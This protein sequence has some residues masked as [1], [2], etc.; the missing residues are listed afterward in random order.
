MAPFR[1]RDRSNRSG[2]GQVEHNVLE[3]L[4]INQYREV[5]ITIGPNSTDNKQSDKDPSILGPEL[6]MPKDSHLLPEHSQ[7]ILR[8]ARRGRVYQAPA[9]LEEDRENMDDE[10]E[11][12]EVQQG[13]TIKKYVKVARHLEGPEPEFLAKRRKGLPSQYA[14]TNGQPTIQA[15]PLRETKVKKLDS[16]GNVNVYKVLVPEGQTVEG[17]VQ[18][19]DPAA[20]E[21]AP[22]TAA[23]GTVVEGV[24]I[25]NAEGVV[26]VNDI[27]QQT[28]P[29]R[30][31]PPP[32]KKRHGPGRGH[33][34]VVA[35][36]ENAAGQGT[37]AAGSELLAVPNLKREGQSVEPSD[38]DGDTPMADA[39]DEEEGE[40]ESDD[41]EA[42][43]SKHSPT[44][45]K[46]ASPARTS[47]NGAS[48]TPLLE[49]EPV[50]DPVESS[51]AEPGIAESAEPAAVVAQIEPIA[52]LTE[53]VVLETPATGRDEFP[54]P[55][56]RDPSSS[57]ELPLSAALAHSRQNSLTQVPTLPVLEPPVTINPPVPVPESELLDIPAPVEPIAPISDI[58][59]PSVE[60][61][62]H[63]SDLEI[64]QEVMSATM[65]V[66]IPETFS[67]TRP[68]ATSETITASI[69]ETIPEAIPET[70][71]E[72]IRDEVPPLQAVPVTDETPASDGELDLLGSLEAHLDQE[73]N[74]MAGS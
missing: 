52:E 64:P 20:A 27:A 37:P 16:E 61:V 28:P 10:D 4:P 6:P 71:P 43:G 30:R 36:A 55:E 29:R 45:A 40:G 23:P 60:E 73:G 70:V 38:G 72:T 46:S 18:A 35:F 11:H 9:P 34:K 57:P 68:Q 49:E 25:V 32:K 26:V 62:M 54:N 24:G 1:N 39:G 42:D 31:P 59:P 2:R 74:S 44:P 17:E 58:A 5:E 12:K 21:V 14:A 19:T 48:A 3:G 8:A 50:Q 51:A 7:Q 47:A 33:K 63:G 41:E 56:R 22:A 53:P 69:P 13:F 65:P 66:T 15:A 67:D